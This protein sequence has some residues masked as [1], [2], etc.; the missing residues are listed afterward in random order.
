MPKPQAL[1][2]TCSVNFLQAVSN[3]QLA[4]AWPN[5]QLEGSQPSGII[6]RQHQQHCPH[7]FPS[8]K[9]HQLPALS[10]G[11]VPST[12]SEAA[13]PVACVSASQDAA[14]QYS[15]H[16]GQSSPL[17]TMEVLALL[18]PKEQS[19]AAAALSPTALTIQH[20][21]VTRPPATAAAPPAKTAAPIA[22]PVPSAP[23]TKTT[24]DSAAADHLA[25]AAAS[26]L[27][28][29]QNAEPVTTAAA[30]TAAAAAH[31][32]R[33]AATAAATDTGGAAAAAPAPVPL[34]TPAGLFATTAPAARSAF[35]TKAADGANDSTADANTGRAILLLVLFLLIELSCCHDCKE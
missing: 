17:S 20:A 21:D 24:D 12:Q 4:V 6:E 16:K 33:G 3:P 7:G 5:N 9:P 22:A 18:F 32:E 27:A 25:P 30:A 11:H 31:A 15:L 8:K 29:G 14:E 10:P 23:T 13:A 1:P 2:S 34:S 35:A 26:V 19:P 28:P